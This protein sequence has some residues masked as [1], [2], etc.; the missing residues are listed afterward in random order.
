[1][2]DSVP[3]TSQDAERLRRL[4]A[5]ALTYAEAAVLE[6]DYHRRRRFEQLAI[7]IW[8]KARREQLH[9]HA[10]GGVHP[11]GWTAMMPFNWPSA[12]RVPLQ[13]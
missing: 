7:Q 9:P 11:A 3:T 12:G 4:R 6:P 8:Q 5:L 13:T 10:T 1:M 2:A